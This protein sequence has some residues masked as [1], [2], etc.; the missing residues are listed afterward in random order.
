M[1]A[2]RTLKQKHVDAGGESTDYRDA[3]IGSTL[4]EKIMVRFSFEVH[5]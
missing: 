1:F 4:I 3:G 5:F 2:S